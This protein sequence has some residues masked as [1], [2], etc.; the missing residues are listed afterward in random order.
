MMTTEEH[1]DAVHYMDEE[2]EVDGDVGVEEQEPSELSTSPKGVVDATSLYLS[3]RKVVAVASA[4]AA[5]ITKKT[6]NKGLSLSEFIEE[7][8]RA[9]EERKVNN[10]PP[11]ATNDPICHLFGYVCTTCARVIKVLLR[12]DVYPFSFPSCQSTHPLRT[13]LPSFI[14]VSLS[15]SIKVVRIG[16]SRRRMAR[17]RLRRGSKSMHFLMQVNLTHVI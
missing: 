6:N 13:N 4:A 11:G 12:F 10:I 1:E 9:I 15:Q 7:L 5:A 17:R 2:E 3:S 16:P 14:Y 8:P